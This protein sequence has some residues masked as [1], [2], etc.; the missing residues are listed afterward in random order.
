MINGRTYDEDA[1]EDVD[2]LV[3]LSPLLL[4]S[5]SICDCYGTI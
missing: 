1:D 2:N 4:A 3:L 5:I